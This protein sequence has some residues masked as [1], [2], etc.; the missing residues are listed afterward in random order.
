[1][2]DDQSPEELAEHF[3]KQG[4]EAMKLQA[5]KIA[6]LNALTFY[7]RG[8]EM[9]CKDAKLNSVLHANRA[10]VSLKM[11][12]HLKAHVKKAFCWP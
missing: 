3:R 8:L 4:N 11:G 2:Y 1:M 6:L 9:D 12:E 5:S 10:L 7:T